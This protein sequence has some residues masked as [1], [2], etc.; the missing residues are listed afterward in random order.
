[1]SG[2][3]CFCFLEIYA[4]GL[5][6]LSHLYKPLGLLTKFDVR[7]A[8]LMFMLGTC[9]PLLYRHCVIVSNLLSLMLHYKCY[10]NHP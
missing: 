7:I 3:L 8:N 5:H 1:M 6:K 10:R 4:G 2:I 9:W